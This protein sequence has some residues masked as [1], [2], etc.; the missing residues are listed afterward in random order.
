MG[1]VTKLKWST[2]SLKGLND[3][4]AKLA[5]VKCIFS[6]KLK[7]HLTTLEKVQ[8]KERVG[9]FHLGDTHVYM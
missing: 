7:S 9:H 5:G 1:K 3:F 2:S 4:G 8:S 6:K